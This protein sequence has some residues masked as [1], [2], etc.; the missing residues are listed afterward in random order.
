[1]NHPQGPAILPKLPALSLRGRFCCT[2]TLRPRLCPV[3][4]GQFS[5]S[6]ALFELQLFQLRLQMRLLLLIKIGTFS[7]RK[8]SPIAAVSGSLDALIEGFTQLPRPHG[9]ERL[10]GL[11]PALDFLFLG[12]NATNIGS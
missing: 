10:Q 3:E 1:M 7:L 11:L 2:N 8:L 5:S 9:H 4:R 12:H 6:P